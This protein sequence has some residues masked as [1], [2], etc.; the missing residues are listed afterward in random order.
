MLIYDKTSGFDPISAKTFFQFYSSMFSCD[1]SHMSI[2][3]AS[4]SRLTNHHVNMCRIKN[5]GKSIN[6]IY[7]RVPK[8]IEFKNDAHKTEVASTI[9][10]L[11]VFSYFRNRMNQNIGIV[12]PSTSRAPIIPVITSSA[13]IIQKLSVNKKTFKF[14]LLRVNKYSKKSRSFIYD[15]NEISKF[16]ENLKEFDLSIKK[17]WLNLREEFLVNML[18]TVMCGKIYYAYEDYWYNSPGEFNSFYH[19][20][21]A[22]INKPTL[23]QIE[24][25]FGN[26]SKYSVWNPYQNKNLF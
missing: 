2:F 12:L 14:N 5:I 13:F 9:R 23:S 25:W 3:Q 19:S 21:K 11:F 10:K 26:I 18:D 16:E 7:S 1:S 4:K 6:F 20:M 15:W 8:K 22:S 24:S 17:I